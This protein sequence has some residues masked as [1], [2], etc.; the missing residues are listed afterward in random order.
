MTIT[1][2][3][4]D[5]PIAVD[6]RST[7]TLSPAPGTH[8]YSGGPY[9]ADGSTVTITGTTAEVSGT[10]ASTR[11][12]V[13]LGSTLWTATIALVATAIG[14]M[15]ARLRTGRGSAARPAAVAASALAIGSSLAQGVAAWGNMRLGH[16]AWTGPDGVSGFTAIG[17]TVFDLTPL[18]IAAALLAAVVVIR[19]SEAATRRLLDGGTRPPRSIR[20]VHPT[21][22]ARARR[23]AMD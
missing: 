19:R 17:A 22:D 9:I 2:A 1:A 23:N 10:D 13:R 3:T 18:A 5:A 4:S 15:L 11:L 21:G 7:A 14:L 12:A 8:F 6:L 20:P 16:V